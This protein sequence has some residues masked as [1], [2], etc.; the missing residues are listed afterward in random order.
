VSRRYIPQPVLDAAHARSAARAAKDWAT[1]DRLRG[2]IETAG[3]RVLD[4]GLDFR[5]E[6]LTPPDLEIGGEVRYGRSS[7]VPSRLEDP[8]AG[9][10]TV[11]LIAT[12]DP[13]DVQRAIQSTKAHAPAG[14]QVVVVADA[15]SPEVDARL[16]WLSD[17]VEIVRTSE[18]LGWAAALNI[19]LRRSRA[20]I[21]IIL[22]TSVE[23]TGD[24]VGP[25]IEALVSPDVAIAGASGLGTV[26]LRRFNDVQGSRAAAAIEGRVMAFRRSDAVARGPIDER[27]RF[28]RNLDIWWSLVLR[29]EGPEGTARQAVVVGGLPL[30]RHPHRAWTDVP[31]AERERL[32]KRNFYRI[33]QRFRDRA[34]LAEP[35]AERTPG[36][37]EVDADPAT[38]A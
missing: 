20:E 15:P 14:T 29:D 30:V 34:D 19:G 38:E 37:P 36:S 7:S 23:P 9:L 4:A 6:P 8:A 17:G 26:D 24:F 10:A 16:G 3:W 25:L 33:L 5:L 12:E 32:S 11:I 27:F 35:A 31:E 13:D 18:R 22:D 2:E 21:I 1:A 28:H